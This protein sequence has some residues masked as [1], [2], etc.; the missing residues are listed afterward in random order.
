[1]F[2]LLVVILGLSS[3]NTFAQDDVEKDV[4]LIRSSTLRTSKMLS[5]YK[6][7]TKFI[8]DVSLE[9][10]EATFY[11]SAKNLQ[12][13]E[14]EIAGETYY[15]KVDYYYALNGKLMFIYHQF[16][17]YDTQIGMDPPP[18]VVRKEERR[19]YIKDGKTI[20]RITTVTETGN[21]YASE[22][23]EKDILDLEKKFREAIKK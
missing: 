10:T 11:K 8:D 17:R 7:T 6:K 21:S 5:T 9:G 3:L 12:K 20:K 18:K 15:A 23:T 22:I 4:K 14:A 2:I 19:I 16:N 1:M 13:I